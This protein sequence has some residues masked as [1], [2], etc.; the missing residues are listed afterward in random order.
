MH[1]LEVECPQCKAICGVPVEERELREG[2]HTEG[3]EIQCKSCGCDF[4][5]DVY[6]DVMNKEKL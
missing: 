5:F 3:L 6:I 1:A 2:M 4:R